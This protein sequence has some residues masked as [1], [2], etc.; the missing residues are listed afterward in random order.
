MADDEGAQPPALRTATCTRAE[1]ALAVLEGPGDAGR[2]LC[3][4][5]RWPNAQHRAMSVQDRT[6]RLVARISEPGASPGVIATLDGVPVGWASVASRTELPRVR[7]SPSMSTPELRGDLD[8]AGV[9]AVSCFVV[10]TGYRRQGVATALLDAAVAHARASGAH[11]LEGYPLEPSAG[12]RSAADLYRGTVSLFLGAGF[13]VVARPRDG[14][15][16]VRLA[17]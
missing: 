15:A 9:W 7:T 17:L 12:R 6:D 14:R 11:T 4:F 5:D 1:D 10:R 2:C 3:Q 16:I 8:D 13:D